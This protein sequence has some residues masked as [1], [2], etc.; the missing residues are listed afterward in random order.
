MIEKRKV[1]ALELIAVALTKLAMDPKGEFS[2][3][4]KAKDYII[5]TSAKIIKEGVL[6]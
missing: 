4:Q 3:P 2:L 5:Y 1:R 6:L